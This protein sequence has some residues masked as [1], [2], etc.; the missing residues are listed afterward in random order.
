MSVS[1]SH[2]WE[3]KSADVKMLII[4]NYFRNM[5]TVLLES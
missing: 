3:M 5:E 2:Y 1:F 4:I